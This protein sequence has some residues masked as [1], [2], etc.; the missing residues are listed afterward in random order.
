[1]NNY[2]GFSDT[3]IPVQK[4]NFLI[5][6]NST[7]KSSF[8]YL[9]E[10]VS[11]PDFWLLPRLSIRDEYS[12][13]GFEDIVSAWASDRTYIDV[14]VVLTRK[15]KSGQTELSFAVHRFREK[16]ANPTLAC[17][18]RRL[19]GD[20]RAILF[21]G[22]KAYYLNAKRSTQ[23]ESEEAALS[24]FR[25]ATKALGLGRTAFKPF[26]KKIP[27]HAPLMIALSLA[28]NIEKGEDTDAT[29]FL[30]EIPVSM[31]VVSM[32][33]IRT[34]PKR[35]YDSLT[36]EYSSE[37]EHAPF[38]LKQQLRSRTFFDKLA[39][40]GKS[41]GLFEA[42]ATHTFGRGAQNPFEVVIRLKGADLN[43]NNVGYGVSQ[44]LPLVVEF[45]T[46]ERQITFAVQQPEVHLHPK[47]QAALGDLIFELARER[48]HSF[49]IET[50]SDYLID[51]Y[52]LAMSKYKS[53]PESQVIFFSRTDSGNRATLIPIANTGRYPLEQ[54]SQFRDF[55]IKEEMKL[56]SL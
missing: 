56:V 15:T 41:S 7:G 53:P 20:E 40:F 43:I 1:M 38:V 34:R 6:E 35:I 54:P 31:N 14:G 26:P 11:Q 33:P 52:R 24:E 25:C 21:D 2:R 18:L 5:G 3:L 10:L 36:R 8:L 46:S 47:A 9:L 37:G 55:F 44:V 45:L 29:Q 28:R 13:G 39:A 30:F 12:L 4:C 48:K 51:R 49:V 42:I 23:F 27:S 32:A 50:H 19:K 16:D 17:H 22:N